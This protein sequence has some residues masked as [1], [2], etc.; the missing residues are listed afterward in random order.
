[1][2]GQRLHSTHD[3]YALRRGPTEQEAEAIFDF[4]ATRGESLGDWLDSRP[5]DDEPLTAEASWV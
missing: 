5:E 2:S 4:I 3:S 1:V